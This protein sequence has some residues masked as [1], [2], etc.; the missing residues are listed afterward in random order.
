VIVTAGGNRGKITIVDEITRKKKNWGEQ[1]ERSEGK[2]KKDWLDLAATKTGA[3]K[4]WAQTRALEKLEK[5]G[6]T[7]GGK[8][9]G[10]KL[11]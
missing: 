6:V 5:N 4:D 10:T 7:R 8:K 9:K 2:K 3:E 1:R 11:L